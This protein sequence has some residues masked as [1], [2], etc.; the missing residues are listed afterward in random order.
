[1]RVALFTNGIW[2]YVIGGMQKHSYYLVK[3]FAMRGI[4]VDLYHMNKSELDIDKLDIF[5]G[6]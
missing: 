1:M 5:Y 3:Y 6:K 2:P 4:E